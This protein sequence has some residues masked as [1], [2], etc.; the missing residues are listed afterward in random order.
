MF[1]HFETAFFAFQVSFAEWMFLGLIFW[2]LFLKLLRFDSKFTSVTTLSPFSHCCLNFFPE[3]LCVSFD[4]DLHDALYCSTIT[5]MFSLFLIITTLN[6]EFSGWS[7]YVQMPAR[8]WHKSSIYSTLDHHHVNQHPYDYKAF[9]FHIIT[10]LLFGAL[11]WR[12]WFVGWWCCDE[13]FFSVAAGCS[14]H[15]SH[16]AGQGLKPV[17][18]EQLCACL[19]EYLLRLST[20]SSHFYCSLLFLSHRSCSLR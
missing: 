13:T 17:K 1:V 15:C 12:P 8:I 6:C 5:L 20:L 10:T 9:A 11:N 19:V 18:S 7:Q 2:F 3:F 14:A 16:C 4:R